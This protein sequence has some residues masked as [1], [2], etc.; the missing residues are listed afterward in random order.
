MYLE[1]EL[2]NNIVAIE[3]AGSTSV[4]GLCSKPIIDID[5]IIEN[6]DIFNELR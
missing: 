3:H 2:K 4:E 6:Y 1:K 5:V